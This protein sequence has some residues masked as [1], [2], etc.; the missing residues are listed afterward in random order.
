MSLL[1]AQDG[2]WSTITG[3]CTVVRD[4]KDLCLHSYCEYLNDFRVREPK[5]CKP[6]DIK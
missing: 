4:F 2:T 1:G 3:S 6:L 5:D